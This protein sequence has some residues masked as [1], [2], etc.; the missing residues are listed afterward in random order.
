MITVFRNINK[1]HIIIGLK[2]KHTFA[3]DEIHSDIRCGVLMSLSLV[4]S[5]PQP[6][7]QGTVEIHG[8][9]LSGGRI[10]LDFTIFVSFGENEFCGIFKNT[11]HAEVED[12]IFGSRTVRGIFRF[13]VT[14]KEP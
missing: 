13:F 9:R 8:D 1:F 4:G 14:D 12:L 11:V 10:H 5:L 3:V 2:I 6:Y 7:V